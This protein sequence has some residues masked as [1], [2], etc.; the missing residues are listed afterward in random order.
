MVGGFAG[1]CLNA[2]HQVKLIAGWLDNGR[3]AHLDGLARQT[4]ANPHPFGFDQFAVVSQHFHLLFARRDGHGPSG[5]ENGRLAA[6]FRAVGGDACPARDGNWLNRRLF[7]AKDQADTGCGWRVKLHAD[8]AQELD[9]GFFRNAVETI[10][11]R[12]GQ[13]GK[14]LEEDG[15][16]IVRRK[17]GPIWGGLLNALNGFSKELVE[18]T[19]VQVGRKERH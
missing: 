8:Q 12:L 16:R 19:I 14:Q 3:P 4:R 18:I 2:D 9:I 10:D 11:H 5:D 7:Q 17:I 1:G 15:P 13:E 6:A